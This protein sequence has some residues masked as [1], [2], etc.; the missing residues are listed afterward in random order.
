MKTQTL[1]CVIRKSA[2]KKKG[3][4]KE[5]EEGMDTHFS[6]AGRK[7]AHA[8]T[9]C[10]RSMHSPSVPLSR[11]TSAPCP[12]HHYDT[13]TANERL[14][15]KVLPVIVMISLVAYTAPPSCHDPPRQPTC[16]SEPLTSDETL[17]TKLLPLIA[18]NPTPYT[19]P[20]CPSCHTHIC[21]HTL[22]TFLTHDK[23]S[24]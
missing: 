1:A 20:P 5:E 7:V 2:G 12:S 19:A 24:P 13:H 11:F 16:V 18:I 23:T 17:S 10:A 15:P 14:L 21:E 4:K 9:D 3:G 22:L 6:C 8:D